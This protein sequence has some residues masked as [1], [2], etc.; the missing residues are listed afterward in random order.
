MGFLGGNKYSCQIAPASVSI[1][2]QRSKYGC[3]FLA[4]AEPKQ[5]QKEGLKIL[6]GKIMCTANLGV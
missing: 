5:G 4:K 2:S 1:Q 6:W 3:D